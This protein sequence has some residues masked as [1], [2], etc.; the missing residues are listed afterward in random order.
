MKKTFPLLLSTF[1]TVGVAV[2]P[3]VAQTPGNLVTYAGNAGR[4]TFSDV[5]QLSD[6]SYLVAAPPVEYPV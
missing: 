5:L 2:V 1:L 4:E 3:A 6:G